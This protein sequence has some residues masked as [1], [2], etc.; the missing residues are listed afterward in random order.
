MKRIIVDYSKLTIEILDLLVA[1]YPDGYDYSNIISFQNVKGE[2]IKAVEVK[3][4]NINYLV[5]IS[6]QLEKTMEDYSED[7]DSFD[8]N[9]LDFDDNF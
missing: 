9:A 6:S 7:E 2:T 8:D 4:A 3:T 5:K 1:K